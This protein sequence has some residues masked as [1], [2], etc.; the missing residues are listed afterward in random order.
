MGCGRPAGRVAW[1]DQMRHSRRATATSSPL[2]RLRS[3]AHRP[4][5]DDHS[6]RS[7]GSDLS[8]RCGHRPPYGV[9]G[10]AD[11]GERRAETVKGA[12]G[13]QKGVRVLREKERERR[14]LVQG[15]GKRERVREGEGREGTRAR[16]QGARGA[17][18][19]GGVVR[20]G[21]E[22]GRERG[23]GGCVKG[24]GGGEG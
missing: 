9:W 15:D 19:W 12:E 11:L 20:K 21:G 5:R 6:D 24:G 13:G 14:S 3:T 1:P 8:D 4:C 22:W 2:L 16:A 23:G 7:D 10:G 18:V 17:R